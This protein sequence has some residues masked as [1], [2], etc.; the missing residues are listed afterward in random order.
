MA[1][2]GSSCHLVEQ[3]RLADAGHAF[4]EHDSARSSFY[5]LYGCNKELP[6]PIPATKDPLRHPDSLPLSLPSGL[7]D[8]RV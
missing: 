1:A 4:D 7:S 3:D 6:L 8:L 2:L 5:R